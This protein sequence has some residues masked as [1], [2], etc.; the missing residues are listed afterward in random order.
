MLNNLHLSVNANVI[1]KLEELGFNVSDPRTDIYKELIVRLIDLIK[2]NELEEDIIANIQNPYS[3]FYENIA[4]YEYG[5]DSVLK[6]HLNIY[7]ACPSPLKRTY[8]N[9]ALAIAREIYEKMSLEDDA[10]NKNLK[11]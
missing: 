7:E 2:L 9:S 6:Y 10:M 1:L 5:F 4:K 3:P 8:L 11:K